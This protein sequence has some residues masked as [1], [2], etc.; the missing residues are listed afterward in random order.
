MEWQATIQQIQSGTHS[1]KTDHYE[2]SQNMQPLSYRQVI[3]LWC[4]D[5]QF[6]KYFTQLLRDSPFSAYRWETPSITSSSVHRKFEFVLLESSSLERP[7]DTHSF[8][9]KF[10]Q[11]TG[12]PNADEGVLTFENLSGDASLVVPA[13]L[14][15][16]QLQHYCHL[17]SFLR[18]APESQ[19]LELWKSLG[20]AAKR[21]SSDSRPIWI[22]TAGMGV[23]WLH[24]RLDS[25]PKYY[26]YAKYKESSD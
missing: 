10:E 21:C 13:P 3:R 22:S 5:E 25:Y 1:R 23:A 16:L 20:E 15:N 26:G 18:A 17:A 24:I 7:V 2:I 4:E 12:G 8:R 9:S 14:D 6:C 11:V 19:A